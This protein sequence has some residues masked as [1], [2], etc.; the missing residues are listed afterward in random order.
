MT[1]RSA[2]VINIGSHLSVMELERNNSARTQVSAGAVQSK[3]PFSVYEIIKRKID[4]LFQA[5]REEKA[6]GL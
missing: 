6:E 5:E 2:P 3:T 4:L 1:H